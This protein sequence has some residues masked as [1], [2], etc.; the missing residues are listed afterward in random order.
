[1]KDRTGELWQWNGSLGEGPFVV[2]SS[3]F[4]ERNGDR[5]FVHDIVYVR[6]RRKNTIV[7]HDGHGDRRGGP[8]NEEPWSMEDD[9]YTFSRIMERV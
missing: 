8:G 9:P 2:I 6:S 7:E 1:M 3:L 5:A 4:R